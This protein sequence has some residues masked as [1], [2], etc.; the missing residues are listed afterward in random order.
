[1][2]QIKLF[3]RQ[4]LEALHFIY[5]NGLVYGHLHSGNIYFDLG[6]ALPIKLLDVANAITGVSSKYRCY[7]PNLKQIRVNKLNKKQNSFFNFI[8]FRHWNIV[9]SMLLDAC[10]MS[11]QQAKNVQQVL[12]RNFL[13]QYRF[14]F[15]I[16]Y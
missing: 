7:I 5:D 14:R 2:N 3:G 12:L 13:V 6:Q 1:L 15:N 4:I 9:I 10:C 16:Y 11:Y 8:F